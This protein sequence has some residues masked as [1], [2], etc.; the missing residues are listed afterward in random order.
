M[1]S[2]GTSDHY[3]FEHFFAKRGTDGKLLH[4]NLL[5]VT[6]TLQQSRR[7]LHGAV[8]YAEEV[9]GVGPRPLVERVSGSDTRSPPLWARCTSLTLRL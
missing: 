2:K 5:F 7:Y 6:C 8:A 9:T 1:L 4:P 3:A